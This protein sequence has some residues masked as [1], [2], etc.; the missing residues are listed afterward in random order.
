[1]GHAQIS[2]PQVWC[3]T[4]QW[5]QSYQ[6][7]P[8]RQPVQNWAASQ[9]RN[10]ALLHQT[11]RSEVGLGRERPLGGG[12]W[13]G[14]K[15]QP[16]KQIQRLFTGPSQGGVHKCDASGKSFYFILLF[17]YIR[18]SSLFSFWQ[19]THQLREKAWAHRKVNPI[20]SWRLRRQE[21]T[22]RES[23]GKRRKRKRIPRTCLSAQL[24]GVIC[25]YV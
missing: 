23:K 9:Q 10:N 13:V 22:V 6:W 8:C 19:T 2:A 7:R 24:S 17:C 16:A 11:L 20:R 12:G 25:R 1:M 3:Q 5:G 4:S 14:E 21:K 15:I 18:F